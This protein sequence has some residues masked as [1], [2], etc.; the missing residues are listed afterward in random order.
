[1]RTGIAEDAT[2]FAADRRDEGKTLYTLQSF[3]GT[4]QYAKLKFENFKLLNYAIQLDFILLKPVRP[5]TTKVKMFLFYGLFN[6]PTKQTR[7]SNAVQRCFVPQEDRVSR[8]YIAV[9]MLMEEIIFFNKKI[10]AL[11][12]SAQT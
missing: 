12:S 2:L 1:L 6:C 5:K 3:L 9:S 8:L 10:T 11:N 7:R 4:S